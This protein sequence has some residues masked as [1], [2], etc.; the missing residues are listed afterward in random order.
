MSGRDGLEEQSAEK[1]ISTLLHCLG[2]EAESVLSSTN[3][4]T[5]D[6]KDYDVVMQK[7]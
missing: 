5:D 7:F 3:A 2:E 1:Q 4:T 6:R